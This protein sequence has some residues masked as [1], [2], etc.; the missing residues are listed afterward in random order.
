[1]NH[2]RFSACIFIVLIASRTRFNSIQVPP[3]FPYK[4][5]I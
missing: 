4:G 5:N 2:T 3:G 1:M